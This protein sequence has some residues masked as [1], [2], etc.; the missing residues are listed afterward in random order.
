MRKSK[1][2][3]QNR[4]TYIILIFTVGILLSQA[5]AQNA[6]RAYFNPNRLIAWSIEYDPYK[7]LVEEAIEEYQLINQDSIPPVKPNDK[8]IIAIEKMNQ[9]EIYEL[10]YGSLEKKLTVLDNAKVKWILGKTLTQTLLDRKKYNH[11]DLRPKLIYREPGK[12]ALMNYFDNNLTWVRNDIQFGP[13]RISY[14]TRRSN[15]AV[16]YQLGDPGLNKPYT[17]AGYSRLGIST[18]F[19]KCGLQMPNMFFMND[20]KFVRRDSLSQRLNSGWG[21]FGAVTMGKFI[22]EISF[23]S[24][25]RKD[26][27]DPSTRN[28]FLG[29][30]SANINFIDLAAS[31]KTFIH[32]PKKII[33]LPGLVSLP[34]GLSFYRVAHFRKVRTEENVNELSFTRHE[35]KSADKLSTLRGGLMLGFWYISPLIENTFPRLEV[36]YQML[37]AGENSSMMARIIFNINETWGIPVTY[38]YHFSEDD[39]RW[40]PEKALFISLRIRADWED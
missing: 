37:A 14:K 19:W 38:V 25:Y 8:V 34:V 23:T 27:I 12:H 29:P 32:L 6:K 28:D 17:L 24:K 16:F 9:D 39:R 26:D 4:T 2:F 31:I 15:T 5:N 10:F 40:D 35:L 22:G 20:T 1:K 36:Q 7:I 3:F 11:L 30:D 13:D 18:K 33:P 21:A